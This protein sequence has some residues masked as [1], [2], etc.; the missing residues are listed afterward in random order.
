MASFTSLEESQ[1]Y[2]RQIRVWGAEAQT[3]IQKSKILIC[4]MKDLNIEVT[5]NV[6]LAG[7]NITIQ[8]SD[9]VTI[10][11]LSSNYFLNQEDIGKK[12]CKF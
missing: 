12:V 10:N 3:K 1:R 8:D 6:V 4:G 9:I 2:D 5:K 7:M 11:D